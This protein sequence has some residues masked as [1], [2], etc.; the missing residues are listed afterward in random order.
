MTGLAERL[1]SWH[2]L[3]QGDGLEALIITGMEAADRITALEAQVAAADLLAGATESL[4]HAVLGPT[5]YQAAIQLA[6]GFE[7]PWPALTF[8]DD[9]TATALAV[10]RAAKGE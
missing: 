7:Y 3:T 6:T 10:F 4:R 8:A 5:G 1:R 9:A 2:H